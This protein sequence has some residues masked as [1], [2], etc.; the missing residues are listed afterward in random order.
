MSVIE[1]NTLSGRALVR[2]MAKIEINTL[3]KWG[4]G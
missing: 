3:F 4:F 2:V 1:I